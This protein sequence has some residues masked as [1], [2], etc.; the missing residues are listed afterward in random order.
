MENNAKNVSTGKPNVAGAIS[1][2]PTTAT[3][4]TDATTALDEAFKCTGYISDG[5][6]ENDESITVNHIKAWGGNIVHSSTTEAKDDFKFVMLE[7]TNV[8]ALKAYFGDDNVSVDGETGA[9]T[10]SKTSE[11]LPRKAWAFDMV[12]SDERAKRVVIPDG[13]VTAKET[14][15][16]KDADAVG[17]GITITAYPDSNG[18]THYEYIEG[19]D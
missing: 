8:D 18:K 5:G 17:Y 3:L 10:I 19:T 1:Y 14:I 2:A 4:P 13:Q 7:C 9:I 16:Y 11:D 12:L 6:L 15:S